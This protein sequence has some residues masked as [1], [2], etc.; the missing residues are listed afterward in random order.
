MSEKFIYLISSPPRA[1]LKGWSSCKLQPL[2]LIS[3]DAQW[4]L[5]GAQPGAAQFLR[6]VGSLI[7][8]P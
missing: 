1:Y 5:R 2:I 3:R 6:Q 7:P 8:K 4:M